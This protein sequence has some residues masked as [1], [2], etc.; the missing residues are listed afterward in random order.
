MIYNRII[1]PQYSPYLVT[2]TGK[3]WK[4]TP[5][6]RIWQRII[7][8]SNFVYHTNFLKNDDVMK[9]KGHSNLNAHLIQIDMIYGLNKSLLTLRIFLGVFTNSFALLFSGTSMVFW[10]FTS[11]FKFT[12]FTIPLVCVSKIAIF[13]VVTNCGRGA[14]RIY[15]KEIDR[16]SIIQY[17]AF[18]FYIW[19]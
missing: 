17:T 9:F 16:Q 11:D 12:G 6:I 5:S 19:C 2:S 7:R 3:I 14:W 15:K 10:I 4:M 1:L 8:Y 18:I 13:S